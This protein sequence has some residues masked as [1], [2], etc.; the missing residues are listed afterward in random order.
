MIKTFDIRETNI[1]KKYFPDSVLI[2]REGDNHILELMNDNDRMQ[3]QPLE[4]EQVINIIRKFIEPSESVIVDG[5]ARCGTDTFNF[6]S[7]FKKTI[8]VDRDNKCLEKNAEVYSNRR[9]DSLEIRNDLLEVINKEEFDI[10]Y[11]EYSGE[12]KDKGMLDVINKDTPDKYIIL[13]I[14]YDYDASEIVE[15]L[16]KSSYDKSRVYKIWQYRYFVEESGKMYGVANKKIA[17]QLI[18]RDPHNLG[19]GADYYSRGKYKSKYHGAKNKSIACQVRMNLSTY[20]AKGLVNKEEYQKIL[21]EVKRKEFPVFV[22]V[23]DIKYRLKYVKKAINFQTNLHLGQRKLFLNELQFLTGLFDKH[24]Q[25][26]LVVYAGAAPSN[27]IY[28]LHHYFPKIKF[29]LIDPAPFNIFFKNG[30]INHLNTSNGSVVYLKTNAGDNGPMRAVPYVNFYD[31]EEDTVGNTPAKHSLFNNNMLNFIHKSS[32]EFFIVQDYYTVD[33]SIFFKKVGELAELPIYFWS[34]IRTNILGRESPSDIDILWNS[35]QQYTWI[36]AIEPKASMTKFRCT[37]FQDRL[38]YKTMPNLNEYLKSL[39]D[40]SFDLAK[41]AG[42]DFISN[43]MDETMIFL[44]GA[45]NIQPWGPINTTETRIVNEDHFKL[46]KYICDDIEEKYFYYNNIDRTMV[47]HHNPYADKNVGFDHCN[48]CSLEGK[49]W[50]DYLTK[51]S[52][53]SSVI[54]NVRQLINILG[55]PLKQNGHGYLF[56]F[57]NDEWYSNL[58]REYCSKN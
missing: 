35:A 20:L 39:T 14:P 34:D 25:A 5:R 16:E 19:G 53:K 29:I 11:Y 44:D 9:E 31:S 40:N 55:K 26:A 41:A 48:D 18:V 2:N 52:D 36:K 45:A 6:I 17:F 15:Q 54:D 12:D 28:R 27:H 22:E 3:T 21:G 23:S 49:I 32:Y 8:A 37:Y 38:T 43:Y 13:K 47:K 51:Y 42:I 1:W 33:L 30:S 7:V 24:D 50:N 57:Y 56:D 46:K 58:Y 4:G 10:L